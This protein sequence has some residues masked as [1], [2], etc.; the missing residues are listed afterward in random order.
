MNC[1][2][3]LVEHSQFLFFGMAPSRHAT[4]DICKDSIYSPMIP[5]FCISCDFDI[6]SICVNREKEDEEE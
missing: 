2:E 6:C 3:E 1:P 5:Y 4:C